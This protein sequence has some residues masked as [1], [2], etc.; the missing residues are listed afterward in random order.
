MIDRATV[1]STYSYERKEYEEDENKI[2]A[3]EL[4]NWLGKELQAQEQ[5]QV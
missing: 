3:H 1:F 2:G 4:N 5:K